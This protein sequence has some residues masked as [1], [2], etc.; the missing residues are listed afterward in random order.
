M[1]LRRPIAGALLLLGA[2]SDPTGP[3][4]AG[5]LRIVPGQKTVEAGAQVQFLAVRLSRYGDTLAAP[6][7]L[8][9]SS[10]PDIASVSA[11]GRVSAHRTGAVTIVALLSTERATASVDVQRRFK[12]SAVAV[13]SSHV[14]A[15]DLAGKAWCFGQDG[16]G[17]L[18]LG[19][20]GEFRPTMSSPVIAAPTFTAITVGLSASCGLSTDRQ[21]WCWG[22][23]FSNGLGHFPR[24]QDSAVP[25]LADTLRTYEFISSGSS[26]VCG[27]SVGELYC[28]GSVYREPG[29]QLTSLQFSYIS[30]GAF[31]ACGVTT[32]GNAVCWHVSQLNIATGPA[33]PRFTRVSTS[34]DWDARGPYVCGIAVDATLYCWGKNTH[35]QLGDG[36]T[37]SRDAPA[38]VSSNHRFTD[39]KTH[40]NYACGLTDAGVALCWGANDHGQLGRGDST[41]ALVPQLVDTPARFTT[42]SMNPGTGAGPL[43]ELVCAISTEN[44]LYCWGEDSGPTPTPVLY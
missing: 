7:V 32:D 34:E 23:N 33:A 9:S 37:E 42:I 13:G 16:S 2:C 28:W 14:C 38:P 17:S 1:D 26:N 39:I 3:G 8:W 11:D 24:R 35:G 20:F 44:D 18:G 15:L 41:A 19:T 21:A 31:D 27:L 29:A 22:S 40:S 43:R 5:A 10:D 6:G 36:S 30:V 4:A 25:V 12:A